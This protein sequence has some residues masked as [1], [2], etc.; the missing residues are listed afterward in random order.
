VLVALAVLALLAGCTSAA[1]VRPDPPATGLDASVTQFRFDEGTR[2]LKAAVGNDGDR[3]VRVTR[4]TIAWTAMAFTTVP[5][6]DDPVPPGQAAAFTIRYGKARCSSRPTDR[7]ALVAVI[8]GRRTRLPLKVEDPGLLRRLWAKACAEQRLDEVASV[9]LRPATRTVERAGQEYL[10]ADLVVRHRPGRREPVTVVDL[11]GSVLVDLV[12][13]DGRAVL[14]ASSGPRR[15]FALP[16]L[17]GSA[18]RCDA[19]ALGQSSQTFLIS[20]YVRLA[21]QPTQRV[22]LPLTAAERR[23]LGGVVRRDCD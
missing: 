21:G 17:M 5:L 7:P 16:L 1:P 2:R 9:Q 4:A 19:H 22:V 23:R 6:P 20:A 15:R 18:H 14:P 12:P 8:D 11:G 3:D 10:P 13:R